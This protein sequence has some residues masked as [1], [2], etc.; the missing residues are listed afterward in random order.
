MHAEL[1]SRKSCCI[2]I[3]PRV[4]KI[5]FSRAGWCRP[6]ADYK[7]CPQPETAHEKSL[8]PMVVV[9]REQRKIVD[10]HSEFPEWKPYPQP[11]S[12]QSTA[13]P[14]STLRCMRLPLL[15]IK[16]ATRKLLV[17]PSS[18][19]PNISMQ[20]V[21]DYLYIVLLYLCKKPSVWCF[22][23]RKIVC[24]LRVLCLT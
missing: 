9:P 19:Q 21:V 17:N 12:P 10:L 16:I 14:S 5:F 3:V 2:V 15:T 20:S 23:T 8:A 18:R 4:P 6:W 7:A 22:C 24:S 13:R 1:F 11:S